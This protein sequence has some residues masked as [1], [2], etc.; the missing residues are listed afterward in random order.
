MIVCVMMGDKDAS[1]S[2]T[3]RVAAPTLFRVINVVNLR[4]GW[5]RF[6]EMP[7]WGTPA[8]RLLRNVLKRTRQRA[9]YLIKSKGKS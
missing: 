7:F 1:E 8:R 2:A 4:M 9:S 6:W 3:A 5:G